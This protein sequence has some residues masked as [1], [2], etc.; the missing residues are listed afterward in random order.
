M[1]IANANF[2]RTVWRASPLSCGRPLALVSN[3]SAPDSVHVPRQMPPAGFRDSVGGSPVGV[4]TADI[5]SNQSSAHLLKSV[6]C[7]L[8]YSA[9]ACFR[10]GMS[11]SASF[12]SVRKS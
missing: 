8:A 9:L 2:P 1:K 12:Q 11:G 6:H 3:C 7:S 5:C 10:M 4:A